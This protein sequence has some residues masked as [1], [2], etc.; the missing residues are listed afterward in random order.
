[1]G[2]GDPRLPALVKAAGDAIARITPI[3]GFANPVVL[4]NRPVTP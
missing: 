4:P 3:G 2:K 1:V